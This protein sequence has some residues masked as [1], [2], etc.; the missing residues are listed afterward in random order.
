V[1]KDFLCEIGESVF[2]RIGLSSFS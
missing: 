1:A 2:V